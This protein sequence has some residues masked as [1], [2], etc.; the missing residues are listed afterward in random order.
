M[1]SPK[2]NPTAKGGVNTSLQADVFET[3]SVEAT[4]AQFVMLAHAI[5][6][7]LAATIASLAFGGKH[8]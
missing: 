2:K 7:E 4:Q 5:R 8:S 3:L 6:P 1:S